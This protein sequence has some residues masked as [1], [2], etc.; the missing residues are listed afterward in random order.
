MVTR[1]QFGLEATLRRKSPI[2]P[3]YEVGPLAL[4]TAPETV[5]GGGGDELGR[6]LSAAVQFGVICPP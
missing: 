6:G 5:R 1:A 4:R 3:G 2:A